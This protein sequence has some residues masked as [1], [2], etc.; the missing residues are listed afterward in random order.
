MN[1]EDNTTSYYPI[2]LGHNCM[3]AHHIGMLGLR[4]QSLPLD[5]LLSP[6]HLA[7]DYAVELIDTDFKYFLFDLQYDNQGMVV[8]GKYPEVK[9]WHHDLLKNRSNIGDDLETGEPEQILAFE[10]RARRFIDIISSK[11][12]FF[13]NVFR[14]R[15]TRLKKETFFF[16]NSIDRFTQLLERRKATFQLLIVIYDDVDF[17]LDETIQ[18]K[19][20]HNNVHIRKFIR[21]ISINPYFGCEKAFGK[22][23]Q[24]FFPASQTYT[25][26]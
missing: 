23:L 26:S 6:S 19:Y 7:I 1:V 22:I 8:S 14:N 20:L 4:A 16:W 25:Q 18:P 12:A 17:D 21:N 5:W 13:I 3:P 11:N 15:Q 9:F 24:E 10:R 2:P